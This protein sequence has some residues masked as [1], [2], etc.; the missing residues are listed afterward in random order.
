MAKRLNVL[1]LRGWHALR[2]LSGD[3][4]Y[5]LY[6]KHHASCHTDTPA[7]S[8]KDFFLRQQQQKWNGIKR[9]C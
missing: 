8:R 6:L 5:E 7:L 1:L 3:N 2:E 4:A 9:C